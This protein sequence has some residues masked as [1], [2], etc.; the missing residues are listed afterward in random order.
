MATIRYMLIPVK[1]IT[2]SADRYKGLIDAKAPPKNNSKTQVK[3]NA[4]F[5]FT[6]V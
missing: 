4:H 3:N 1:T 2:H 5:L 6:R